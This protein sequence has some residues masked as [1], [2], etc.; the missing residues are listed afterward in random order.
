MA[1]GRD[2]VQHGLLDR[3]HGGRRRIRGHAQGHDHLHPALRTRLD[4]EILADAGTRLRRHASH[5]AQHEQEGGDD[6]EPAEDDGLTTPDGLRQKR[7]ESEPTGE[8]RALA[9]WG[10]RAKKEADDGTERVLWRRP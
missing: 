6:T 2:D 7:R 3:L 9:W 1:G 4:Q 5:R 8:A 10:A